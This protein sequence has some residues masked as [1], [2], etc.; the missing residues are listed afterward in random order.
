MP[1][2]FSQ[3]VGPLGGIVAGAFGAGTVS[4]YGFASRTLGKRIEELKGDLAAVKSD[5]AEERRL[6]RED[7]GKLADRLR[8]I[9]DR[10]YNGMERQ[11]AQARQSTAVIVE[12]GVPPMTA[13]PATAERTRDRSD[14]PRG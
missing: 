12:R 5:Q 11:L 14:L 1:F 3:L 7:L 8:E 13:A 9:E 10:T 6:H 4:G 2:D